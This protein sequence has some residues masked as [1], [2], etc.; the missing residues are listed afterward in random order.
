MLDKKWPI[1]HQ[2]IMNVARLYKE[3]NNK[4][5][6]SKI[7]Q[8][9]W[10]PNK[11]LH[12]YYQNTSQVRGIVHKCIRLNTCKWSHLISLLTVKKRYFQLIFFKNQG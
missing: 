11:V 8:V 5:D 3:I 7:R 4:K 1:R 10:M 6:P 12:T 9:A 2:A